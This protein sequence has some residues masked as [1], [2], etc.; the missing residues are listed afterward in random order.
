MDHT[1]QKPELKQAE[2]QMGTDEIGIVV[3]T[4]P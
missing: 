4:G 3:Q 1:A 2:E